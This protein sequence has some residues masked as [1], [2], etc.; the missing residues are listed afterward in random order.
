MLLLHLTNTAFFTWFPA[1]GPEPEFPYNRQDVE[2]YFP[3]PVPAISFFKMFSFGRRKMFTRLSLV[4]LPRSR[5]ERLQTQVASG[6][7]F[8]QF[9]RAEEKC[10]RIMI[11]WNELTVARLVWSG[12]NLPTIQVLITLKKWQ[13]P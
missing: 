13:L 9:Q 12:G 1:F 6:G 3:S 11:K 7:I 2:V 10:I 4:A 5:P 8:K